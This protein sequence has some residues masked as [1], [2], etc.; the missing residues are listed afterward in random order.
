MKRVIFALVAMGVVAG[1]QRLEAQEFKVVVNAANPISEISKSDASKIFQK[2]SQKFGNGQRASPVDLP[3]NSP[4]REQ[5]SQGVHGRSASAIASYWQQQIF[6]GRGVPPEEKASDSAVLD[7]VR[8]NP[9]GIGYVA[10]DT[11]LGDGVKVV[12]ITG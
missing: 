2:K 4:V 5:F 12:T 11:S 1:S 8:S 6:S 10:A 7:F 3:A 9:D